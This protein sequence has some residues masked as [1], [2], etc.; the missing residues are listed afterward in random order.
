MKKP[1]K[2]FYSISSALIITLLLIFFSQ[3]IPFI[4]Y[5]NW[6][7]YDRLAR[8]KCKFTP[9]PP[10]IGEILLVTID[11]ETLHTM[12]QRWPYPRKAYA[13]AICNLKR[14]GAKVVAFDMA[15]LGNTVPEDDASLCRALKDYPGI[16]MADAIN[17]NGELEGSNIDGLAAQIP[18]GFTTKAQ[19][20]DDVIRRSLTY[21]INEKNS[22]KA[23]LSW[24][25]Q[26]LRFASGAD[27][28]TLRDRGRVVTFKNI[29]GRRWSIPVDKETKSFLI[30]FAANTVNF[31]RLS[32]YRAV[33]GD[34][35]K[36][37]PKGKVCLVGFTSV[38]L[39]DLH[40]TAIGWLPGLTLNANAFLTLY[41]RNFLTETPDWFNWL[42]AIFAVLLIAVAARN[43]TR[44][45]AAFCAGLL[46]IIFFLAAYLLLVAGFVLNFVLLPLAV[47]FY[48][49][50]A[51]K[52]EE[53]L[54]RLEDKLS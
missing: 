10:E 16:V 44:N 29:Y 33:S 42:I 24:G 45:Q 37:I 54:G 15:F 52:L 14:A 46:V 34:F 8:I 22:N 17:E 4:N 5:L 32:F 7:V 9:P 53:V 47:V 20:K 1:N 51:R 49:I 2:H 38:L 13:D 26:I 40:N 35:D 23:Y 41:S 6:Q 12:P 43:L 48:L 28:S 18:S 19:D 50:L 21:L 11:N 27:L 36:N 3:R 30:N 31:K 39:Q 25:M